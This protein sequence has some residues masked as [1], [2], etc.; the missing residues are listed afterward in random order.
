MSRGSRTLALIVLSDC[1]PREG[2]PA[3]LA[4]RGPRK[5]G[6]PI[7]QRP[8]IMG[9]QHKRVYARLPTRYA[10]ERQQSRK[11][12]ALPSPL[13]GGVGGGGSAILSQVAP[14]TRNRI[15]P[16]PN[17]PP[18]GGREHIESA[19]TR[20]RGHHL[21]SPESASEARRRLASIAPMRACALLIQASAGARA[22]GASCAS[23][24]SAPARSPREAFASLRAT[25]AA[26]SLPG[27]SSTRRMRTSFSAFICNRPSTPSG[28]GAP[29]A[30]S[31]GAS[32][33]NCRASVAAAATPQAPHP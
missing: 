27:A 5:R 32:A 23:S 6:R 21:P 1:R 28:G 25:T 13:W 29:A 16:L 10:R 11:L 26:A 15:T 17:P 4:S 2:H 7:F 30:C 24:A 33:E 3:T 8:V 18:Q 12:G 20:V 14:E 22:L 9:S 19:A 31:A